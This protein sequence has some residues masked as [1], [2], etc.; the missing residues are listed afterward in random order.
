MSAAYY[1]QNKKLTKELGSVE[2]Y[3]ELLSLTNDQEGVRKTTNDAMTASFARDIIAEIQAMKSALEDQLNTVAW[4]NFT[5]RS[6][7]KLKLLRTLLD[8]GFSPLLSRRLVEKLT[9]E[10]DYESSLKQ[11]VS[12]LVSNLHTVVNDEIIEKGGIYALIGPTGVGKTT[13]TAKLAARCV[14]R[15]GADRVA[16][17][18]TDSYRIGGHEQLRIYGRLL[19]IPVRTIKDTEDLQLTL[20]ELRNKHMVL[21]DTVGMSQRDQ[22]LAEQITMLSNCGADVKRLLILSAASNGKTLDEVVSAYQ[23]SGIYGCIITKV[24][25]AASLGVALDIVIRRKLVLHYVAN[26]QKVPE[27]IHAANPRY[28]LHR[29]FKPIPGDSAFTLQDAEFALVMAT[30]KSA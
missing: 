7:E 18:T 25:E 16:L 12:A 2:S 1:E 30:K 13:T 5:Q 8:S 11:A 28:L 17:L 10:L 21:I 22:M 23:K 14:I 4:G 27:D 19:G 24:D 6:P 15:H 29:V 20:S 26:G 9:A 3:A